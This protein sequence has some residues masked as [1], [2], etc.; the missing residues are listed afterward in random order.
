MANGLPE[1]HVLLASS[2]PNKLI[3]N[4]SGILTSKQ[5]EKIQKAVDENVQGLFKLGVKH[6]QFAISLQKS[7]WRQRTSRLYYAAYNI[8]RSVQLKHNGDYSTD[9]SDHKNVDS[10]PDALANAAAY[11]SKLKNM[12]DDRNLADYS[13][14]ATERDLLITVDEMEKTV[15][16]F[17]RDAKNFL[18]AKG[19]SL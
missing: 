13:H 1:P 19:I 10:I 7:E 15:E 9:S 4:L 18:V 12:R 14:L 11:R 16:E 6:Y 3:R 17:V 5:L 2:N 8:R